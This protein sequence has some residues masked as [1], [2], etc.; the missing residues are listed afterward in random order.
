MIPTLIIISALVFVIIELP[1][2]DYFE[3]YA[4]ELRAQGEGVDMDKLNALRA[5]Y[6]I[7][8]LEKHQKEALASGALAL[9]AVLDDYLDRRAARE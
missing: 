8:Q 5:E 7:K 9:R 3:S 4:A 1:P 6:A 2:G